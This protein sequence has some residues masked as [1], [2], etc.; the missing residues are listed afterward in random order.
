MMTEHKWLPT[1]DVVVAIG[2]VELRLP[3]LRHAMHSI[4]G[5]R[6]EKNLYEVTVVCITHTD[7]DEDYGAIAELCAKRGAALIFRPQRDEAFSL[8]QAY[9]IGARRGS[10]FA[11]AFLNCDIYFHPDTFAHAA[12]VLSRGAGAVVPV[13]RGQNNPHISAFDEEFRARVDT[14]WYTRWTN[15]LSYARSGT[16]NVI[17]PRSFIEE[18]HGFDER[19]YGWGGEDTDLF[20]RAKK[21]IGM[22]HLFD[23]GCPKSVHIAH[24]DDPTKMGELT[25]RNRKMIS[26]SN[27]LVRNE[28]GWGEIPE[29]EQ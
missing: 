28:A 7:R 22:E 25:E 18:C 29:M 19:F 5:Q 20:E 26:K 1:I 4:D 8:A 23:G 3:Y 14:E 13:A 10:R 9:N 24:A 16:G 27:S 17:Y 6:Y 12:R 11:I 2:D 15:R 21:K